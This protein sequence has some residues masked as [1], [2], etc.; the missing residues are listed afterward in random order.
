MDQTS[1]GMA[2]PENLTWIQKAKIYG[3]E[4][5]LRKVGPAAIGSLLSLA[6]AF[7][8]A[9]QGTFESYGVNY[10][11]EWNP[12]WLN[13]HQ[14]S[15]QVLLLELDTTSLQAISGAIALVVAFFVTGGHHISATIKGTPQSGDKRDQAT[16]G[17]R[18]TDQ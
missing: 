18:A 16:V 13:T 12:L 7:I 8:L 15:G 5:V 17:K 4:V 2:I 10:I 6:T 11:H 9:H 14:I 3:I 1:L